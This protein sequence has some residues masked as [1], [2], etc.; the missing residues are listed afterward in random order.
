MQLTN[1]L[2]SCTRG[3]TMLYILYRQELLGFRA[4]LN[5]MMLWL[6]A[7]NIYT[8]FLALFPAQS[9]NIT[10]SFPVHV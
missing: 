4:S 3:S 7:N 1:A 2:P 6:V 9:G 10:Q 5:A 8:F